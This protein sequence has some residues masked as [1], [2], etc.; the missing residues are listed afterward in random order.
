M[1]WRYNAFLPYEVKPVE[2]EQ[3]WLDTDTANMIQVDVNAFYLEHGMPEE[4]G[5]VEQM[6]LTESLY[7]N[8]KE[9][10]QNNDEV[11]E[12]LLDRRA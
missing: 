11:K 1:V 7:A 4:V 8:A 5:T 9:L 3:V 10:W 6:K 12:T 2:E